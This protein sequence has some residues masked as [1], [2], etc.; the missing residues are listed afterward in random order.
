MANQYV[1]FRER[2]HGA[3][4][5]QESAENNIQP[6]FAEDI[7]NMD[8]QPNGH[9]ITRRG[10]QG[11]LGYM[12]IRI[13]S[14]SYTT[15]ATSNICFT[16]PE[17][18]DLSNI[19]KTPVIIQGKTSDQNSSNLGD[20]PNNTDAVKYFSTFTTDF[21]KIFTTG[22]S[23]ISFPNSEHGIDTEYL[24]IQAAESTSQ[25][26]NSNELI[27]A[28]S[29]EV[30]TGT[31]D[32]T[33][34][35]TNSTGDEFEGFI[36]ALDNS[37]VGG[38]SYV[39]AGN[40]V[41]SGA[42]TTISI[43][44]AT[45]GLNNFS[46]LTRVYEETVGLLTEVNPDSVIITNAGTVQV[47][48]T[49]PTIAAVD[50]TI[51]LRS[52]PVANLQ[53]GTIASGA[54]NVI[55]VLDLPSPFIFTDIFL[56]VGTDL[57]KIIPGSITVDASTNSA[58]FTFTNSS[59][60]GTNFRIFY[61][62]GN[63]VTNRLCLSG[64]VIGSAFN[65]TR[66]QLTL[67]GL[68]PSEIYPAPTEREGWV[69][70]IDSY[71]SVDEDRIVTGLGG[72]IFR[73]ALRTEDSNTTDYLM[74]LLYPNING[75][76][77]GDFI[78]GPVFYDTVDSPLRTRGFVKATNAGS[79]YVTISSATY[80][81][82]TGYTRYR[83][84]TPGQV[85][86]GSIS[87]IIAVN[88]D[89]LTV[90]QMGYSK[91]NGT[92]TVK[93]VTV[94]ADYIDIDV[95]NSL[96]V[97]ND[98]DE[99]DAGGLGGIFT[100]QITLTAN[101]VF[102]PNDLISDS[103]LTIFNQQPVNRVSGTTVNFS[104][105]IEQTS[106]P[107]GL[108][109]S[110]M[111]QTN[112]IGLRDLDNNST[113]VNFLKGDMVSYSNLARLLRVSYVRTSSDISVT[114][115]A[116]G[117]TGTITLG[118]GDTSDLLVG[119]SILLRGTGDYDGG[120]I[121]TAIPSLSILEFSTSLTSS[122]SGTLVGK[123]IELDETLEIQDK[124]D[125]SNFFT[126]IG[127]F[128]PVEAPSD[129]FDLTPKTY[130]QHL[131]S[132]N[133]NNQPTIRSVMV[134]DN[135]YFTNGDDE[136]MK[137]DG[138]NIYRAGLFRWQPHLFVTTNTGASA[139]IVTGNWTLPYLSSSVNRFEV[140]PSNRL[141]FQVGDEI[142]DS[143]DSTKYIVVSTIENTTDNKAYIYVNKSISST[144]SGTPTLSRIA[145]YQ[146]YF[147]LNA[148]DAN[149]N[150][151][152]SAVTGSSDFVVSLDL[153]ASVSIRLVGMPAWHIYDYD[154]IEVQIYRTKANQTVYYRLTT[155]ALP[156]NSN[157]G[158]VDYTDTA[159]DEDLVT[160]D[161]ISTALYGSELA[162]TLSEP[163]RAKY[164]TSA[165]NR[166]I[167]SN[168]KDYPTIDLRIIQNNQGPITISDLVLSGNDRY[169]FRIDNTDTG[170]TTDM[171]SRVAYQFRDS[172]SAQTITG[173]TGTLGTSFSV[174]ST[175]HGI[176]TAG[177]WVY[178]YHPAV[179]SG[180][181]LTYAG[182]YQVS[183]VTDANA[184]VIKSA[185][186][187]AGA[188]SNFPTRFVKAAAPADVPVF[189]GTDGNYAMRNGNRTSTEP[190]EFLAIRRLANAINAS[191]RNVDITITG[192]ETFS[193]WII[194][195][196]G[197]EFNIGQLVVRQPKV[198][199]TSLELQLPALTG[200]FDIFVNNVKRLASSSAGQLTRLFP[201]RTI[202]SFS[203]FPELFDN[204]TALQDNQSLSAVDVNSA[205]GQ[206]ITSSI[207]FFGSSAF[208]AS[209][210][211]NIV[212][213][214]KEN[215]IYLHNTAAKEAG[216]NPIQ[217]LESEG[218]GCTA[219]FSVA[220]TKA[221]I[222]FA[223]FTGIYRL[224]RDL[225]IDYVGR[226]Y[227]R[228]W[229]NNVDRNNLALAT[230]HNFATGNQYKLSL[231]FKSGTTSQTSNN[232]VAVYNHTRESTGQGVG[233]WTR[234]TNHPA[235]GYCNLLDDSY[236]ATTNGE[237]F[238]VRRVG[239]LTDF[240]DD[241][242]GIDFSLLARA[243]DFGDSSIRKVFGDVISHYRTFADDISSIS[244]KA[245]VNLVNQLTDTDSF[246]ISNGDPVNQT[247]NLSDTITK[248]ISSIRSTLP[249]RVGNY[250]QLQYSGNAKDNPLELAG[251][252]IRVAA[253]S[254]EGITEA[255]ET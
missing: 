28:D 27:Y 238:S 64:T 105:I 134:Q 43:N 70:L 176:T 115:V 188:A 204:P 221:G 202:Q 175:S 153:D 9:I 44:A 63:L 184:F 82:G 87:T 127:R 22:T 185:N 194:G 46:I 59:G 169:L 224:R 33:V 91:L 14:L 37:A 158:Y 212:V 213:Q 135:L 10:Y 12:P 99:L 104:S 130:I 21:R 151:V 50:Y 168:L 36:Y 215:S 23:S 205:D 112:I 126:L 216:E 187:E 246:R 193:P 89:T 78:I 228:L 94:G 17:G 192:Y 66:P 128:V 103:G 141:S 25:L 183:S 97:N 149:E 51:L 165:D 60:S 107:S 106:V 110:G 90:Q 32:V 68:K 247:N 226:K 208:G 178:L 163:M 180:N 114:I 124:I 52:V 159:S 172:T 109:L 242:L 108:R 225:Q 95:D 121:I 47:T 137:F 53:T 136:V 1:P 235:T 255:A 117:T 152:A 140:A 227:E 133:Y 174:A 218:K 186:S 233:S 203:N 155:L 154:R 179:S 62:T 76:V 210:Q 214:F 142:V 11:Y 92:F 38:T 211:N 85:I 199:N 207:P 209:Q 19:A 198:I 74:P 251:I 41:N 200:A 8:P 118:S 2:D 100:D 237:V 56:E 240:R 116:D 57:E 201:S 111:R 129:S 164:I 49:N 232:Q 101:T 197:N 48:I 16:L 30:N 120:Q 71:R 88:T 18:I 86:S 166:L 138:S 65:D 234:Y 171:L 229:L 83:L 231:P 93:T 146:Y 181:S 243:M 29:I 122:V 220:N 156:F 96:V 206:E 195:N 173:I 167:L 160:L 119:Q 131:D 5:D 45:H 132:N 244:L 189:L 254:T 15:D 31:Y 40:T 67:W 75:R 223:N 55:T 35:Y 80:Q 72:N 191:M 3:G 98:T 148:V 42:T 236:M 13:S 145:N 219:P 26:D 157:D 177:Q 58:T 102:L 39:S 81:S 162:T 144:F 84:Q 123:T 196:A 20:F 125:S 77:S 248:K 79:H 69:T 250:L 61:E 241:N 113:V 230:G 73:A 252:D 182:W 190:Y 253:K 34:D 249:T 54:T 239:D 147:R 245:G 222:M 217:K 4:L 24:F 161:E 170:T 7:Q 6:G 143:I 139:K 150:I